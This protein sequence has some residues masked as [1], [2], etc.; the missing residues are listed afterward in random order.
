MER[1]LL[2]YLHTW[3]KGTQEQKGESNKP[4]QNGQ[5]GK[6]QTSTKPAKRIK[7]TNRMETW[8]WK[9]ST[10]LHQVRN[11]LQLNIANPR[12]DLYKREYRCRGRARP[13]STRAAEIRKQIMQMGRIVISK[14]N[15]K[16][17]RQTGNGPKRKTEPTPKRCLY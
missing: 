13:R 17:R 5:V 16:Y 7:G 2:Q 15:T 4:I 10:F 8:K 6:T 3:G 14:G 1:E 9:Q 11:I 12:G